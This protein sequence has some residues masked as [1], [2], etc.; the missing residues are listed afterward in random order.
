MAHKEIPMR[1]VSVLLATL[2]VAALALAGFAPP[3]ASAP[4]NQTAYALTTTNKILKFRTYAPGT[5]LSAVTITGIQAGEKIVGIDVRPATGELWAVG[6]SDRLYSV[7]PATGV[8]TERSVLSTPLDG[9]HFGVDFNPTVDRLRIVSDAE[10]NLRVNVDTGA[11]TVDLPLAYTGFLAGENP[12]VTAAAYTNSQCGPPNPTPA[13][14]TPRTTTLYD[15]DA[16]LDLLDTQAPPNDGT[17]NPVGGLGLN[18]RARAGFDISGNDGTAFA[19]LDPVVP[20]A[21]ATSFLYRI[22]LANGD[23]IRIGRIGT[24]SAPRYVTDVAI[25]LQGTCPVTPPPA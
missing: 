21:D 25:A 14:P 18:V 5:I 2:L 3:A 20:A 17:L 24:T 15:L 9:T 6:D 10:Q 22:D 8:A 16:R 4:S 23:A 12:K 7:D 13:P 1:K 19:A 11:V